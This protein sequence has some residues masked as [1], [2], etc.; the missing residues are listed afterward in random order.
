V[1]LVVFAGPILRAEVGE[2]IQVVFKNNAKR[3]YSVHA[4]G[5]KTSETHQNGVPQG[6]FI[7]IQKF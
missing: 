7:I 1:T 4:H 6:L 5:V 2:M 3:P